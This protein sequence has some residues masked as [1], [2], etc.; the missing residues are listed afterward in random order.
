M[1][2]TSQI[3]K[4]MKEEYE[5]HL[6]NIINEV[7]V[8]DSRGEQV[9]G[10]DLKVIHEPSGLE[11]TVV[12]VDGRPG[13]AKVTLRTPDQPRA[14]ATDPTE[15]HPDFAGQEISPGAKFVDEEDGNEGEEKQI[16]Y[17]IEAYPDVVPS[18]EVQSDPQLDSDQETIFVIDEKEF[19]KNYREA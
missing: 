13:N 1:K 4:I 14:A 2:K 17:G 10:K 9:I 6:L 19:E 18:Q 16:D 8:F 11:Y 7:S 15:I 5:K 3:L 12:S